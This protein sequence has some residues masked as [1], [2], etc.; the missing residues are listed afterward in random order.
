MARDDAKPRLALSSTAHRISA[1]AL[2]RA[3]ELRKA[4]VDPAMQAPTRDDPR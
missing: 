4:L 2:Q 3:P 1:T